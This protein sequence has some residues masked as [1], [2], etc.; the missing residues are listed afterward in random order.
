MKQ[1]N[2][3]YYDGDS[4]NASFETVEAEDLAKAHEIAEVSCAKT[5]LRIR[6][7]TEI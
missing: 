7:I 1:F 5:G 3:E 6:S 4:G 2:V